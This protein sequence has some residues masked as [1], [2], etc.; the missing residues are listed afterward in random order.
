VTATHPPEWGDD[1][2]ELR[3]LWPLDRDTAHL[4]HGSWGATPT[5]VLEVQ[6]R[7]RDE[8]ERDPM[9]FMLHTLDARLRAARRPVA[10]MLGADPENLAFLPNTTTGVQTVLSSLAWR[11]GDEVVSTDHVYAGVRQQLQALRD[12]HGVE[13]VEVTVDPPRE[14]LDEVAAAVL[15]G[16]TDR[17][18]LVVI[19]SVASASAMVF[20][21]AEIAAACRERGVPVLV[22]AAHAPGL[23]DVDLATLGVDWRVGNL[24]KWCCTPKGSAVLWVSEER[25]ASLRPLVTSHGYGQGF[26]AEFDWSGTT[27]PTAYLSAPAALELL[28]DVGWQRIRDYQHAL[29][30]WAATTVAEA[31]GT[32][33]VLI[34]QAHAAM[35]LVDPGV[36]LDRA[37]AERLHLQIFQEHRFEVPLTWWR[38]RAWLRLSA[39]VYNV[40]DEYARLA[41]VLPSVLGA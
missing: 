1:W 35:T 22:D 37:E 2:T 10:E 36:D 25:R 8:L 11:T 41:D 5:P 17:T 32:V 26:R 18:R 28:G 23:V 20:P 38:G 9:D 21:V 34:P 39:H 30:G 16:V 6:S 33:P 3:A 14:S 27:D 15:A 40:P 4:N 13:V 12:R 29:A 24:H 7:L 31:V 19:D